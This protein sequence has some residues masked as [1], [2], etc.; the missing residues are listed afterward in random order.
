MIDLDWQFYTDTY[1]AKGKH[2]SKANIAK[3]VSCEEFVSI[4]TIGGRCEAVYLIYNFH[5]K[6]TK[7][8]RSD[9]YINRFEQLRT[10][11]GC[12]LILLAVCELEPGYDVSSGYL[13]KYLHKHFKEKKVQGEWF[14]LSMRDCLNIIDLF[15]GESSVNVE[16]HELFD[17]K[18]E[19]Q[20]IRNKY[21]AFLA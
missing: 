14:N 16:V 8:G 21:K 3:D 7:I 10:G 11:S 1:D 6:L 13:E 5:T 20:L 12:E 18:Q 19:R 9:N 15:H 4:F 2:R 17:S